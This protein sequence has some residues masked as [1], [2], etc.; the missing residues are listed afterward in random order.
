VST[1]TRHDLIVEAVVQGV[2][3]AVVPKG[4]V[5]P[6]RAND[7][8]SV[9]LIEK[10][11]CEIGLAYLRKHHLTSNERAFFDYLTA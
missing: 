5:S 4:F 8:D 10:A 1:L 11:R 6:D 3:L 7:I 2:G 9:P